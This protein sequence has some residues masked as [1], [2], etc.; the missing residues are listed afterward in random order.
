MIA[1]KKENYFNYSNMNFSFLFRL[2][3]MN[4][5]ILNNDKFVSVLKEEN[6]SFMSLFPNE[7]EQKIKSEWAF[8]TYFQMLAK[9]AHDHLNFECFGNFSPFQ[10]HVLFS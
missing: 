1:E 6:K 4:G 3:I 2:P 7:N 8:I 5:D 10:F 9:I